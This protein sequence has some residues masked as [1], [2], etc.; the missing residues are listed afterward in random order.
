MS[1]FA[2]KKTT[3]QIP[4]QGCLLLFHFALFMIRLF[5]LSHIINLAPILYRSHPSASTDFHSIEIQ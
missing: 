5:A 4:L 2:H 3:L 1:L